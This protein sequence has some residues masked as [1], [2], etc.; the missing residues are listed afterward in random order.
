MTKDSA[1]KRKSN[2]VHLVAT[3]RKPKRSQVNEP[4]GI[5]LF[6]ALELRASRR[7]GSFELPYFGMTGSVEMASPPMARS[8][9]ADT[10]VSAEQSRVPR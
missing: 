6:Q 2:L 9:I 5:P 8:P 4:T 3:T 10:S 1:I 7:L